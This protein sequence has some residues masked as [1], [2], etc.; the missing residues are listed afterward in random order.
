M[1]TALDLKSDIYIEY[2]KCS[3]LCAKVC[4]S[5]ESS[6][7]DSSGVFFY[8]CLRKRRHPAGNICIILWRSLISPILMMYSPKMIS[9]CLVLLEETSD[10]SLSLSSRQAFDYFYMFR[11]GIG[12]RGLNASQALFRVQRS[13]GFQLAC[14]NTLNVQGEKSK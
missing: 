12:V 7:N 6:L 5:H 8:T 1:W 3:N 10:F 11:I 2:S 9:H 13:S 14:F 4:K